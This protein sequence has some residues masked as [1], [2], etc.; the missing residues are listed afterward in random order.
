VAVPPDGLFV[1][2]GG[3]GTAQ[4]T[5]QLQHKLMYSLLLQLSQPAPVEETIMV[6]QTNK[7][8]SPTI[9]HAPS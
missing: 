6:A 9:A 7:P 1:R 5:C 8:I 3:G 2:A 4:T